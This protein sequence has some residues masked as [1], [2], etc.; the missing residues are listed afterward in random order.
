[1]VVEVV[2]VVWWSP[3]PPW[4][5]LP[6][7]IV[8]VGWWVVW[9]G[10]AT[11]WVLLKDMVGN[12]FLNRAAGPLLQ[13]LH[14]HITDVAG[15]GGADPM[16]SYGQPPGFYL[17]TVW[18]T[19][20][21][22]SI[23]LVPAAY[24]VVRRLRGKTAIAIDKRPYQFLVAWIVPMW[25][26]L[27][28]ARGKLFHYP[29]PLFVPLAI[30]CADMLVQ[31]WHRLTDVLAAEW[32]AVMR[33]VTLL[34]W[35]G[36][37]VAVLVLAKTQGGGGDRELLWQCFPFAVTLMAA[38]FVSAVTWGRPSW[39]YVV[40][41]CWGGSLLVANTLILPGMAELQVSR[42]A[43]GRMR[44]LKHDNP[45]LH[46]AARG[47]EEPTLVFYAGSNVEMYSDVDSLLKAVPF[48]PGGGDP[49]Q[50]PYVVAVDDA[51]KG[52]L[53]RR[54]L[55]FYAVRRIDF[56]ENLQLEA[57]RITGLNTA[58]FKPV[59]VT[60]ISNVPPPASAPASGPATE[61]ATRESAGAKGLEK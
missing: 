28:A 61:T 36:M 33:W 50:K 27:E 40:V 56:P 25:I 34:I 45:E 18:G 43:G 59:A 9:A 30:V 38:G 37:G 35:V 3:L 4:L 29:L 12:H 6:L 54:G 10:M 49:A 52:A 47:Y 44:Q 11:N 20:W 58:N 42:L 53:E 19:F 57:Y 39:P 51:T 55:R 22:W 17:L 26:L 16:K 60:L 48:A 1:M 31:S 24:F 15:P 13:A 32:F 23:L 41:L 7:L 2:V 21:P 8:L 5:S 46:L 14:I